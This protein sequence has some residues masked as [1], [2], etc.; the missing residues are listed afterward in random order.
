VESFAATKIPLLFK[1][2][3]VNVKT[4]LSVLLMTFAPAAAI[5][6]P[7]SYTFTLG[8]TTDNYSSGGAG[9]FIWDAD[10]HE[11]SNLTWDFGN[12]L[13]GG[14][15]DAAQGWGSIVFGGTRGEFAFEIF[16]GQDVHPSGCSTGPGC[17]VGFSGNGVFGSLALVEFWVSTGFV[18]NFSYAVSIND[19]P[20]C[21]S[22]TLSIATVSPTSEVPEPGTFT[23]LIGGIAAF[24]LTRRA[25]GRAA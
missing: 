5:A 24:A 7:V 3:F 21:H 12:G 4:V 10:T 22:G 14:V 18:R 9:S 23:L 6:V 19:W 2:A 20:C 1:E 17:G 25:Y 16:T 11:F 8:G 15:I 13:V